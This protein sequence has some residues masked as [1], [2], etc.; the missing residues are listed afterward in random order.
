M[1]VLAKRF[2]V[3]M[4]VAVAFPGLVSAA[5]QAEDSRS[6]TK[7]GVKKSANS[8]A[9]AQ[10][11]ATAEEKRVSRQG[12]VTTP[13][14][15]T[16]TRRRATDTPSSGP[17]STA[18]SAVT[19]TESGLRGTMSATTTGEKTA[20]SRGIIRSSNEA[21]PPTTTLPALSSQTLATTGGAVSQTADGG[22]GGTTRAIGTVP[23]STTVQGTTTG[24]SSTTQSDHTAPVKS[25]TTGMPQ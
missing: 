21:I 17:S 7:D 13:Q 22:H 5:N 16:V 25:S 24:S 15:K 8:S 12:S 9:S 11:T 6:D 14:G 2:V 20:A 3:S 1:Q 4:L 23:I 18:K 10:H 19:Q